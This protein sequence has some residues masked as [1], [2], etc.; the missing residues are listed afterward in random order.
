[1]VPSLIGDMKSCRFEGRWDTAE[2]SKLDQKNH[3]IR[4]LSIR[5]KTFEVLGDNGHIVRFCCDE[6]LKKSNLSVL[7]GGK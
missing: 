2:N 3:K 4:S 5:D 7:P 6:C 1:M